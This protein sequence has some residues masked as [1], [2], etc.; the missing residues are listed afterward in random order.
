MTGMSPQ[1]SPKTILLVNKFLYQKGG[2]ATYTLSLGRLLESQG[3]RVVY[4]GMAH[5]ENPPYA[6][7]RHFVDQI[8]STLR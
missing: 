5:P 8:D 6:Q 3:H 1:S 7:A 4:W 2:D